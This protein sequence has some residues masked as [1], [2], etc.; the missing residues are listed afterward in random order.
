M[1]ITAQGTF[2]LPPH[3]VEA[4]QNILS[5]YFPHTIDAHLHNFQWFLIGQGPH[6]R[7]TILIPP[8]TEQVVSPSEH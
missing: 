5:Y 6:P 1:T 8:P 3:A 2:A 7:R 4:I